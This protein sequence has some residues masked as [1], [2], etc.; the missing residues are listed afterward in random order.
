MRKECP[1]RSDKNSRENK[2]FTLLLRKKCTS[3]TVGCATEITFPMRT[4]SM[5]LII[6]RLGGVRVKER[7]GER[8]ERREE[9]HSLHFLSPAV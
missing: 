5:Y 1:I 4:G 9:L 3:Q 8:K 6:P 2:S 7:E